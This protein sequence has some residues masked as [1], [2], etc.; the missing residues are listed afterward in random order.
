MVVAAPQVL[1]RR[2]FVPPAL[3]AGEFARLEPLYQDLLERR[4]DTVEQLQAW[5]ADFAELTAAVD[6]FGAGGTS[7]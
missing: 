4:V 6:E 1:T 2:S 7:T 3:D 5:L